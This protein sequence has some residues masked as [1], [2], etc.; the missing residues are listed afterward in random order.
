VLKGLF[1][2]CKRLFGVDIVAADGEAEVWHE[3]VRFFKVRFEKFAC[4]DG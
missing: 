3:D 1:G 4:S 2:L